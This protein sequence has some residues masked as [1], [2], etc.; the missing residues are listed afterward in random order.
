[1]IRS[2]NPA[3]NSLVRYRYYHHTIYYV[4]RHIELLPYDWFT[5]TC[6]STFLWTILNCWKTGGA[7][8]LYLISKFFVVVVTVTAARDSMVLDSVLFVSRAFRGYKT[9]GQTRSSIFYIF[10]A[11]FIGVL[12]V[13][14]ECCMADMIMTR[15]IRRWRWALIWNTI[16]YL[17]FAASLL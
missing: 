9:N 4:K 1:M 5:I 2:S 15:S 7:V 11:K 16:N 12:N 14:Y 10:P 6:L 13:N 17:M 8:L 3:I